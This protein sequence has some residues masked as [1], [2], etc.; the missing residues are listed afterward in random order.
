MIDKNQ[1]RMLRFRDEIL[2]ISHLEAKY[3]LKL[4]PIYRSFITVFHNDIEGNYLYSTKEGFVTSF[5]QYILS[6]EIKDS[7]SDDDD[8]LALESFKTPEELL[9]FGYEIQRWEED[10][11]YIANH[12][13]GGGLRVG[14]GQHNADEIYFEDEKLADNI[15]EFL[16]NLIPIINEFSFPNLELNKIVKRIDRDVWEELE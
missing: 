16:Q 8:F 11:A 10:K 5:V 13:F 14:I 1:I 3:K 7:Y 12:S 2:D 6:N 9:R 4:P 15:F